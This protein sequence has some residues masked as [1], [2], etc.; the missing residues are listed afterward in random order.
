MQILKSRLLSQLGFATLLTAFFTLFAINTVYACGGW[1]PWEPDKVYTATDQVMHNGVRYEAKWWTKGD[2]PETHSG[3]WKVWTVLECVP[4]TPVMITSPQNGDTFTNFDIVQIDAEIQYIDLAVEKMEFYA[5]NIKIG[6]DTT[7][8]YSIQSRLPVDG[9]AKPIDLVAK[10]VSYDGTVIPSEPVTL[11]IM[12][13][14]PPRFYL[15]AQRT[16]EVGVKSEIIPEGEMYAFASV[17]FYI[18]GQLVAQDNTF[19]FTF[20]WLPEVSGDYNLTIEGITAVGPVFT[21]SGIISAAALPCGIT[22]P[23]P[24]NCT[25]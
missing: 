6:E 13:V 10:A 12:L 16:Y 20:F 14:E 25:F 4:V 21:E 7:A 22:V 19:P 18:D 1:N 2:N 5:N 15:P 23:T 8:P 17:N 9:S 11:N 24:P 3:E